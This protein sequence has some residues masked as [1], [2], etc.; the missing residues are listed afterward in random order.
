MLQQFYDFDRSSKVC[1]QTKMMY[2][3]FLSEYSP[4][5]HLAVD[6]SMTLFKRRSSMKQYMPMKPKIKRGFKVWSLADSQTEYILKFQLYEDENAEKLLDRTLRER[7]VLT[8]ADGTVPVGSQLFF[9]NF[10]TSTKLLQELCNRDIPTCGTF[11][12]NK[13]D[14]PPEVKV[15]NKLKRGSY[16]WRRKEDGVPYQWRD[17][18]NVHIM[19]NYHDPES[20]S[21]PANTPKWQKKGSG[22]HCGGKGLKQLDGRGR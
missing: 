13:K 8:L 20:H 14:L 9:V 21:S 19:S 12:T 18:K 1:P 10:F 11:C 2:E 16:L 7:V 5:S 3:M 4:S 22:V 15:D 6:E 17:S